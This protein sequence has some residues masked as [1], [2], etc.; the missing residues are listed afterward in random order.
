MNIKKL[1]FLHKDQKKALKK[2]GWKLIRN[3]DRGD[4]AWFG[5]NWDS[6]QSALSILSDIIPDLDSGDDDIEGYDFLVVAYREE[7]ADD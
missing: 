2:E 6:K 5:Q 7:R 1:D 4:L 3:N